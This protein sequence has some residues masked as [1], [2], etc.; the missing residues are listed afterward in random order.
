MRQV[1]VAVICDR[2]VNQKAG[3]Q[4]LRRLRRAHRNARRNRLTRLTL[5]VV[6]V[7]DDIPSTKTTLLSSILGQSSPTLANLYSNGSLANKEA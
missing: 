7:V 4:L 1:E 6:A 5:F 3:D 2:A